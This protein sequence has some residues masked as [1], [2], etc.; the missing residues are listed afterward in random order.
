MGINS[1][2]AVEKTA[3]PQTVKAQPADAVS[4]SIQKQLSDVQRQKQALTS[5]DGLS[6]EERM[7]KRKEL[8]QEISRLN[9]KLR[10][11]QS[12]LNKEQNRSI[13]RSEELSKEEDKKMKSSA[14]SE[15]DSKDRD[16]KELEKDERE[17]KS[18]RTELHSLS[19]TRSALEESKAQE[20]V[21]TRMESGVVILKGEIK[22]DK[23]RGQNVDGKKE[24]L[25]RQEKKLRQASVNQA[26]LKEGDR[27]IQKSTDAT[28]AAR[29][30]EQFNVVF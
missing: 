18:V 14:V 16:A 26:K 3:A 25:A 11:R 15:E 1:V 8:Q 2:N 28:R 19:Q 13:R 29:T 21:I 17:K 7:K 4:K 23:L 10:Q 30:A 20:N 22:Q 27:V 24:E 9:G 12:E 5:E 6:A